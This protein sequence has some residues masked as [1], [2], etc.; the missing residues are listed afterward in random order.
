MISQTILNFQLRYFNEGLIRLIKRHKHELFSIDRI[1]SIH[2]I[3]I[4][5]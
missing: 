5:C 3:C 4:G 2:I 1:S